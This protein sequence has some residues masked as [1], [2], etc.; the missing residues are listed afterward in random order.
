MKFLDCAHSLT[1]TGPRSF[2]RACGDYRPRT[3]IFLTR[4]N[5][6]TLNAGSGRRSGEFRGAM[7]RGRMLTATGTALGLALLAPAAFAASANNIAPVS[8]ATALM[9]AP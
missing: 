9:M 7:L 2:A 1:G 3:F 5:W 6:Y 4:C 8:G